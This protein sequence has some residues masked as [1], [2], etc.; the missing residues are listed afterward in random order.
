MCGRFTG[1]FQNYLRTKH[2][3]FHEVLLLVQRLDIKLMQI[4]DSGD[5]YAQSLGH[6]DVKARKEKTELKK[7]FGKGKTKCFNCIHLHV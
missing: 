7:R 1:R 3:D 5:W 6:Q 2:C 4:G